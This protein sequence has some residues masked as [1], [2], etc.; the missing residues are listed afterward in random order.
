MSTDLP[1][2]AP[3]QPGD[4]GDQ[5]SRLQLENEESVGRAARAGHVFGSD[6]YEVHPRTV[7]AL[8]L[9]PEVD[10]GSDDPVYGGGRSVTDGPTEARSLAM[11]GLTEDGAAMLVEEAGDLVDL[12]EDDLAHEPDETAAEDLDALIDVFDP[13]HDPD[14]LGDPDGYGVPPAADGA[15]A[16]V[17]QSRLRDPVHDWTDDQSAG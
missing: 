1:A 7:G 10:D 14:D 8:D 15:S 16:A 17:D 11:T 13:G 4:Q 6:S 2:S 9:D 5:A 3:D 12:D